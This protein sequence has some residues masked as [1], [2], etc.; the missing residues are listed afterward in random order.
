MKP[1]SLVPPPP[2]GEAQWVEGEL[3]RSLMRTQRNTQWVGMMLVAIILGVLWADAPLGLTL[4]WLLLGLGAAAWRWWVLRRYERDVL[5]RGSD[6]HL[7]FYRRHRLVWPLSASVW[8]LTT[9]LFFDR[10]SLADQYICWL[11]MAGLAMFSINSL[12]S[13]LATMRAYLNTLMAAALAVIG[14][15]MVVELQ[16]QGPAYHWWLV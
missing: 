16:L 13:Q 15:R 2:S 7:A 11:A 6:Q 10:S 3:V 14:W 9:L 4:L 5:H 8:G 12:S 1:E